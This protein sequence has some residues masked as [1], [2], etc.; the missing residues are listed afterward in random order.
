MKWRKLGT[1]FVPD[2][3][4][5]WARRRAY[6]PTPDV[7]DGNIIRIYFSGLDENWMGRIGYVDLD[8]MNPT[9]VLFESPEPIL[10]IGEPGAFDAHSVNPSC[11]LNVDGKKL[12]YYIG[13]QRVEGSLLLMFIGIGQYDECANRFVRLQRTPLLE[14][15]PDEPFGRSACSISKGALGGYRIWYVAFK[16]WID[17]GGNPFY[18]NQRQPTYHIRQMVSSNWLDWPYPSSVAIDSEN[19]DEWGIARPWAVKDGDIHRMWYSSR[20][21]SRNYRIGYAES[22]SG[23]DWIRK[24]AEV[25]IDVSESGWDSEMICFASIADAGGNRYMFYNGNGHGETGFGLAV[26]ESD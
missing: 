4:K 15:T 10:D 3:S 6:L 18:R 16:G 13:W 24:D 25:G 11:L 5:W 26:L 7:M 20:C 17:L 2:G 22:K 23:W 14:R 9:K 8:A 19:D 21:H 12:L 1:V